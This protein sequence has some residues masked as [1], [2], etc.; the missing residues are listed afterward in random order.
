MFI[1]SIFDYFLFL[2]YVF[3]ICAL[4]EDIGFP[5]S[6]DTT[7]NQYNLYNQSLIN[8][9]F[10]IKLYRYDSIRRQCIPFGYAGCG[11]NWN[12]FYTEDLCTLRCS[13]YLSIL[14]IIHHF[15]F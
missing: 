14:M 10:M 8:Q 4:P 6:T 13:K 2:V 9:E 3:H 7:I 11:G 15:D 12:H 5:C 1:K